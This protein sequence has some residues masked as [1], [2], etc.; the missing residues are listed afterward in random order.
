MRMFGTGNVG[1]DGKVLR[2]VV[3]PHCRNASYVLVDGWDFA[4]PCPGCA[5]GA[6]RNEETHEDPRRRF[7][8]RHDVD[9]LTWNGGL[10][11]DHR[12]CEAC[13][14]EHHM[15]MVVPPG[16]CAGCARRNG[17]DPDTGEVGD[18]GSLARR[19]AAATA[20]PPADPRTPAERAEA[21]RE[22]ER[23][24]AQQAAATDEPRNTA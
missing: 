4:A 1:V 20:P 7:W 16:P 6:L 19:L 3:C 9:V 15:G 13:S 10:T 11:L 17:V 12:V 18:V 8:A 14:R 2:G 23:L 24:A 21:R 22:L 5:L